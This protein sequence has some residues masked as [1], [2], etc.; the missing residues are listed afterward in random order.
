VIAP[1]DLIIYEGDVFPDWKGNAL[2]AGLKS[3][4]LVRVAIDA[5]NNAREVA[6]YN[7]GH[8]IREVAQGPKGDVW[9][10]EDGE[11]GRLLRLGQADSPR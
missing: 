6:R 2:I 8:R 9:L 3:Q 5:D 11:G 7:M 4:A 10:L 1:A